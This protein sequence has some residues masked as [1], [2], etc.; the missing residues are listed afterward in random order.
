LHGRRSIVLFDVETVIRVTKSVYTFKTIQGPAEGLYKEKGSK[1]ISFAFP[2]ET[3]GDIRQKLATLQ[4]QYHDARHHCYGWILG[5]ERKLFRAFDD[6]EPNHSAGDPILGQ[7]RSR[8][9]TNVLLV[10][11]RYFGGTKLG[12]S[13]LIAAYRTAAAEALAHATI[14]EKNIETTIILQ[15]DYIATP[16]VMKLIKDFEMVI[17]KKDFTESSRLTLE[18]KKEYEVSVLERITLLQNTGS[19]ISICL[20][21]EI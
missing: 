10:V 8:D 15:Y 14:V 17:I 3:E 18:F 2:V 20:D 19:S 5:H 7:L 16:D 1:F 6:G 9:L 11:I 4:K 21:W 12:V 13:G